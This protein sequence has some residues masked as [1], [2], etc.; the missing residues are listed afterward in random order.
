MFAC[1]CLCVAFICVGTRLL[2]FG[3]LVHG[4]VWFVQGRMCLCILQVTGT[5]HIIPLITSPELLQQNQRACY[6]AR[7]AHHTQSLSSP[8]LHCTPATKPACAYYG[9]RIAH[10]TIPLITS[11]ELM[12]QN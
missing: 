6:G 11:P 8:V 1:I 7:V 2:C 9:A 4:H 10:H 12:R 3:P 5:H